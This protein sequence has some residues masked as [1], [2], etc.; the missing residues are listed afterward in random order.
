MYNLLL[1]TLSNS[2][3]GNGLPVPII[4]GTTGGAV[5][6]L[7]ILFC[8][9]FLYYKWRSRKKKAYSISTVYAQTDPPSAYR[10]GL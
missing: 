4:A 7:I 9:V 3:S 8:V 1:E 5:L 2:D 10:E 6:S